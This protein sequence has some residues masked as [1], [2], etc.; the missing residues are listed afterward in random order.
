MFTN[1]WVGRLL[2]YRV[3]TIRIVFDWIG[4]FSGARSIFGSIRRLSIS[5]P[6]TLTTLV[7]GE[8][9]RGETGWAAH[10]SKCPTEEKISLVDGGVITSGTRIYTDGSKT[11]QG[12]RAA[13]C[14]WS[15]Q[16]IVYR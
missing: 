14:V 10:L 1:F 16:N 6:D 4:G 7:P 9:E 2:R 11:E 3:K 8:V 12:V 15:E 5:L 13:F